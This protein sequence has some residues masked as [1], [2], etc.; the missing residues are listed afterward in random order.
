MSCKIKMKILLFLILPIVFISCN[1]TRTIYD[2]TNPTEI[3]VSNQEVIV[4]ARWKHSIGQ[5]KGKVT[6]KEDGF[7][8]VTK[9]R[10][11]RATKEIRLAQSDI[12]KINIRTTTSAERHAVANGALIGGGVGLGIIGVGALS[13]YY[14][15]GERYNRKELKKLI[16]ASEDSL[17]IRYYK[18][19]YQIPRTVGIA[20]FWSGLIL[21]SL[22]TVEDSFGDVDKVAVFMFSGL[23]LFASGITLKIIASRKKSIN[24]FNSIQQSNLKVDINRNGIGLSYNF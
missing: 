5:V 19:H 18:N 8:T 3:I 20:S 24:R 13:G 7:I 16:F 6:K 10:R 4:Y 12:M 22:G 21:L 23:I 2:S 17:A 15:Q 14:Y 11:S 9:Y 1:T